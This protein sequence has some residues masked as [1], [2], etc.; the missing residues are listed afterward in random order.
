[1]KNKQEV[2]KIGFFRALFCED[3]N[4]NKL[5]VR[6]VLGTIGFFSFMIGVFIIITLTFII[7]GDVM[8]STHEPLT[9]LGMFSM[10]LLGVTTIDKFAPQHN[11]LTEG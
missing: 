4:C 11:A 2:E 1:M 6:R 8:T 9:S 10:L 7:K 5:C 3:G